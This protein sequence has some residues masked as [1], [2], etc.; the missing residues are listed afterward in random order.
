M[1]DKTTYAMVAVCCILL[2]IIIGALIE[3][4]SS[5]V[6]FCFD[7][8]TLTGYEVE[9]ENGS[10]IIDHPEYGSITIHDLLTVVEKTGA[11]EEFSLPEET[12]QEI[13][14]ISGHEIAAVVSDCYGVGK[15]NLWII[16]PEVK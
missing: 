16:L 15:T 14:V 5:A 2:G 10:C 11:I 3:T 12:C 1:G 8:S 9:F 4:G 6:D 13:S 7:I